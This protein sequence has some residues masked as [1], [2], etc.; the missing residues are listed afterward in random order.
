MSRRKL[1]VAAAPIALSLLAL[2]LAPSRPSAPRASAPH[3]EEARPTQVAALPARPAVRAQYRLSSVQRAII[4]GREQASV[5]IEGT[6][7]TIERAAGVTEA[8][9]A[10]S[11]IEAVGEQ[12]PSAADVAA[13]FELAS[14]DGTLRAI[15]FPEATP[16]AG[17]ALLTGLATTLQHTDRREQA[18][19]VEEEDLF[20]TYVAEYERLGDGRVSRK[21][22]AYTKL[23]G[24]AG[25]APGA[26]GELQASERTELSFD[27]KGL[28]A[29][30][31]SVVF[32]MPIA[33]GRA[34]IRM[35]TE[36]KLAREEVQEIAWSAGLG[37][38][39]APISDHVDRAGIAR[40]RAETKVA[41]AT[42]PELVAEVR[43]AAHLDAAKGD[44]FPAR[45]DARRRL[46]SLMAL[47]DGAAK[48]AGDAIRRD[49]RDAASVALLTSALSAAETPSGANTLAALFE[50]A[51][52]PP[53]AKEQVLTALA[54]SHAPTAESAAALTRALD[55]P[56]GER[57]ALALGAQARALGDDGIGGDAVDELLQR[58]AD[59]TTPA[60]K[61]AYLLALGNTGSPKAL[62]VMLAAMRGS[63]FSLA[64]LATRGLRL[65]PGDEV[66]DV[67]FA[68]I[69]H[70]SPLMLDAI[71]A[72]GSRSPELWKPRLQAAA[73][74]FAEHDQVV[75]A[76]K[77]VLV[78]WTNLAKPGSL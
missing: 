50:D 63:D 61:R 57:A 8:R 62:D 67:L 75:D 14:V 27:E 77:S 60:D 9:F 12:A 72:A 22:A 38:E 5:Q 37:L 21:R 11:R 10:A 52:L 65:I 25:L 56:R 53:E 24:A 17:R 59:A 66:D 74:Q 68:L 45:A 47:D 6:W 43:R 32:T 73:T 19:K 44:P 36:A 42:A 13:P 34:P 31:V 58:Y 3:A 46:T 70:G 20:G 41:G 28:V 26:S 55:Q 1:V 54:L 78:R 39:A 23:R 69:E 29:A 51:S 15:A 4:D 33:K 40:R 30:S 7:T 2:A 49:P 76:I 71:Q 35:V 64:R 18:W 16:R 48:A